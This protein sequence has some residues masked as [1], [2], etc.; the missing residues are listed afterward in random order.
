MLVFPNAKINIGLNIVEKRP[1]GFHNI[2]SCFYP[3]GWSDA[4]EITQAEQFSFHADGIAIP[5]NASD[6]LCIKAYEMLRSDYHLPPVKIHLLKTVPIGA[7]LG[8]G[9]ADAAFAIKA[10][11]QLFNLNISVGEQEEYAR[12]IGSDCA[13][14]IRNKPMYC[15]GKGD[16][17]DAI[18]INISGK[19][20]ALVNPGIH[21]STVEAY[22]G[23]VAKR[24]TGD[25]RTILSGPITGWKD[26]VRNDFE[27]TL[28]QKYPLL[29]D[30]KDK[31]YDLG[32]EY[33]AMSGSG[34]T[35]FGI[36]K[37][38]QNVKQHFPDFRLW[39]GFLR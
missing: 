10:L 3:V 16:E 21:I 22:S 20:I 39:Q 4:L 25:L 33:A 18:D 32:A 9:S 13:F 36:F 17:F 35:L 28:F 37:E 30:T 23:V 15:F 31:L 38:E 2:E 1:D 11:N 8:G 34:S 7:G 27:A 24:S 14:F 29:A 26:H 6:N 5:G 19:W 12:R